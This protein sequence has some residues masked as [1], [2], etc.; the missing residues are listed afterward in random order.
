[1]F[2]SRSLKGL[3]NKKIQKNKK[4]LL[5][6]QEVF[7]DNLAQKREF[8]FGISS[9][10]LEVLLSRKILKVF[11]VFIIILIFFL[12][13]TTFYLQAIE[14]NKYL[15]LSEKNKFIIGSIQAS[16]GVIYDSQGEQLVFNKP[17]Y[18]L[19]FNRE[20][21]DEISWQKIEEIAKII[22]EDPL[23]LEKKINPFKFE[24]GLDKENDQEAD[25]IVLISESL[26]YQELIVLEARIAD[27]PGFS[28]DKKEIRDYKDGEIFAHIIGYTG[29]ISAE[30]L[31]N[32]PDT[33]T[34][35]DYIG[36]SGIEK[37][38]E[39]ILRKNLGKMQIER[40]AVGNE[41]S[42][43]VA[44]LP[45]SGKSLVLWLDSG[46]QRKITE[47]LE[48]KMDEIGAKKA[49]GIALNPKTGG[50][51]ALVNLP[52][53][54]NNLFN[55]GADSEELKKL[56]KDEDNEEYFFNRAI[57]GRYATGSTIK[58]LIAIAALQEKII[59]PLKNILCKGKIIIPN[60]YHPENFTEKNDWTT[61]GF[62]DMRKA[63]AESCNV[64]FYTMGGGYEDQEGLGPS[65]IKKYLE[66][67]GWGSKTEIDIPGEDA[68]L[69]PSPEWKREVKNE[70][71][72][73]G[74]TYNLAIGQGDV[75]ITPL[76]E[77]FAFVPIANRGTL[78]KPQIVRQIIDKEEDIRKDIEPEILI[79]DFVDLENIEVVRQGM[80][81]TVTGENSP[82]ATATSLNSLPVAVA[83]KTGSAQTSRPHYYHNWITVFAP[84]DD[85]EIVLT[86]MVEDA[87][88]VQVVSMPI[89]KEVLNW[90]FSK[91]TENN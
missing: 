33:Y 81:Q 24:H 44:S 22:K 56:L 67:F 19:F 31:E 36:I 45:K 64:Y 65:R 15:S 40:D 4:V 49:V 76:Q 3:K 62:T 38:Y 75:S 70:N 84:Y 43:E 28:I 12:F 35:Y 7:L 46:L 53:F 11:F 83:A 23:E 68:G 72:W 13:A 5:E 48:K 16:R 61:H 20:R 2:A 25:K 78:Y 66:L 10:R 79:K 91:E 50:V 69:I 14:H 58:P 6:P 71:W 1:M 63:I 86:I 73:D 29:K 55:Q 89:A 21:F 85:P 77:T 41:I 34:S 47:E 60:K 18:D 51:M 17:S 87:K 27:F 88:D 80:R 8:D 32:F 39:E 9:K 90:Y 82:K 52:S 37:S 30:E 74:D 42:R 54:D 57:A 26:D 59:T